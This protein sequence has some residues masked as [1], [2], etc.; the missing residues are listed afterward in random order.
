MPVENL[1]PNACDKS[2]GAGFGTCG[3]CSAASRTCNCSASSSCDTGSLEKVGV[4]F[5]TFD[6]PTQQANWDDATLKVSWKLHKL[7]GD[8]QDSCLKNQLDLRYSLDGGVSWTKFSGFPKNAT[9]S[10]QT[11]TATKAL[12]VNQD[13]SKVQ[14]QIFAKADCCTP[15]AGGG[16]KCEQYIPELDRDICWEHGGPCPG[17]CNCGANCTCSAGSC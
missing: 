9:G 14:V 4:I 5:K 1:D 12:S 16:Y 8:D 15:C 6:S 3:T 2:I 10:N 13:I 17:D 7:N 11:G